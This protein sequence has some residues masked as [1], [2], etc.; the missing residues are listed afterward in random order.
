MA[1]FDIASLKE[2]ADTCT[3]GEDKFYHTAG[4]Q[5]PLFVSAH[6]QIEMLIA[7]IELAEKREA[8]TR[9]VLRCALQEWRKAA[10][11]QRTEEIADIYRGVFGTEITECK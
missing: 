10:E 5:C 3:C 11:F 7:R 9:E 4:F 6:P 2:M 8:E 1:E